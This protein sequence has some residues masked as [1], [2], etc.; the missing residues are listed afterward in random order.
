M[1][2]IIR[3]MKMPTNCMD[4]CF[5]YDDPN[6]CYCWAA[7]GKEFEDGV[8]IYEFKRAEWCPLSALPENHGRLVDADELL[9][10]AKEQ[11]GPMTGDG[12]DN[13]GVY[14]LIERQETV[15]E[16]EDKK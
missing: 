7:D 14:A 9:N 3:G 4:C 15:V 8:D 10:N 6:G 1:S 11:S 12:W 13:L 2:V 5:Q 16:V